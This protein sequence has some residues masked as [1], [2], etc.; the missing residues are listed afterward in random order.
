[1]VGFRSPSYFHVHMTAVVGPRMAGI[2]HEI[3]VTEVR[4]AGLVLFW[5]SFCVAHLYRRKQRCDARTAAMCHT[6]SVICPRKVF[7]SLPV[8]SVEGKICVLVAAAVTVGYMLLA[9]WRLQTKSGHGWDL[10]GRRSAV[11]RRMACFV[12]FPRFFS[13]RVI[14]MHSWFFFF[15]L[16]KAPQS[17][18]EW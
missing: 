7:S 17:V 8:R 5:K 14:K 15:F 2:G 10:N 9:G 16:A 6:N 1:M 3:S 13:D 12:D 18:Y 4:E 11:R